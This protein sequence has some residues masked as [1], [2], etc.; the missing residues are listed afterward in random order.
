MLCILALCPVYIWTS[1]LLQTPFNHFLFITLMHSLTKHIQ[2]RRDSFTHSH[3]HTHILSL[4]SIPC[5]PNKSTVGARRLQPIWPTG[6]RESHLISSLPKDW[7]GCIAFSAKVRNGDSSSATQEPRSGNFFIPFLPLSFFSL[8][9]LF[10]PSH[11]SETCT[12][13]VSW[14]GVC[15]ASDRFNRSMQTLLPPGPTGFPG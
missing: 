15:R 12:P 14:P 6:L 7:R 5:C 10:P 1:L 9:S 11:K 13:F 8:I 2:T 4:Q 3:T